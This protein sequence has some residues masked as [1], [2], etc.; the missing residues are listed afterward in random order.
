MN[1]F[2]GTFNWYGEVHVLYTKAKCEKGAFNNCIVKLAR[3]LERSR[4]SVMFYF[5][6][7]NRDNWEIKEV[8]S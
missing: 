5:L 2:K 3:E 7:R 4:R 8:H 1:L 6:D